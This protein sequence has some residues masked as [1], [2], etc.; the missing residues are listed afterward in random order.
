M[1]S[2]RRRFGFLSHRADGLLQP[3]FELVQGDDLQIRSFRQERFDDGC[4]DG[5]GAGRAGTRLHL[6]F[7]GRIGGTRAAGLG[8]QSRDAHL[9]MARRI[10][11]M[12]GVERLHKNNRRHLQQ[13]HPLERRCRD[14][15]PHGRD[16]GD[17]TTSRRDEQREGHKVTG[18]KFTPARMFPDPRRPLPS[19][20]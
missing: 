18:V 14:E 15:S 13:W 3:L 19:S 17:A 5:G 10:S 7:Q 16:V 11:R 1:S 6:D 12:L 20:T 9:A 2:N 4:N 8:R